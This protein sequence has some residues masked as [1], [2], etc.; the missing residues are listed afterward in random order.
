MAYNY[1]PANSFFGNIHDV[2][3]QQS[4]ERSRG[5]EVC[6]H[7]RMTNSHQE[8]KK[9][10]NSWQSVSLLCPSPL[11]FHRQ[12]SLMPLV[13]L[14]E[15]QPDVSVP[16]LASLSA[17]PVLLGKSSSAKVAASILQADSSLA[18][19]FTWYWCVHDTEIFSS[20]IGSWMVA[21]PEILDLDSEN[22]SMS[23]GEWT[24]KVKEIRAWKVT[25]D[26]H[27]CKEI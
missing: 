8:R 25:H 22:A 19:E 24:N 3:R 15:G 11:M 7:L 23:W 17:D 20:H 26:F 18:T 10:G 13:A 9:K 1:C 12:L 6:R 27:L 4:S 2:Q 14:S 5:R 21:K 16:I